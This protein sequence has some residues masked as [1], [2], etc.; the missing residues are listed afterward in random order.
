MSSDREGISSHASNCA[1]AACSLTQIDVAELAREERVAPAMDAE[2]LTA[3]QGSI[4][5]WEAIVVGTGIDEGAYNCPLCVKFNGFW[6]PEVGYRGSCGQCP[7]KLS[8]KQEGCAGT[9]YERI[10]EESFGP[11]DEEFKQIASLEL[12]FLKSLL[13]AGVKT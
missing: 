7:V 2:T 1:C 3:L 10:E 4:A 8:T 5:K 13:P 9:P 11:D 6:F 12:S